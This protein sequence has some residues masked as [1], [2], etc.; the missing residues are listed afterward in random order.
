MNFDAIAATFFY[1]VIKC[2]SV[3]VST[4]FFGGS[5][6]DGVESVLKKKL[7]SSCRTAKFNRLVF[8]SS[9]A[10]A[11]Q[12][13]RVPYAMLPSYSSDGVGF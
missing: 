11:R 13:W 10:G 2:N 1:N 8:S 7:H 4:N 6:C 9:E 3:N 5:A 12:A